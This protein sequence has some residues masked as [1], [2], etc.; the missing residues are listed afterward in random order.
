MRTT[1]LALALLP[2]LAGVCQAAPETPDNSTRPAVSPSSGKATG[3]P[4]VTP[5]PGSS[6]TGNA[7][8]AGGESAQN[9]RRKTLSE[10]GTDD[11]GKGSRPGQTPEASQR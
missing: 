7:G 9:A 3:T 11:A 2:G 10:T 5:V 6:T 8:A 4:N 1:L